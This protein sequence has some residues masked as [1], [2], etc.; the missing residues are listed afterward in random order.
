[1]SVRSVCTAEIRRYNCRQ[2]SLLFSGLHNSSQPQARHFAVHRSEVH[3]HLSQV[4]KHSIHDSCNCRYQTLL[5][6]DLHYSSQP[7]GRRFAL[8]SDAMHETLTQSGLYA[9]QKPTGVNAGV[10][11]CCVLVCTTVN[12]RVGALLSTGVKCM[13]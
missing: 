9:Q 12:L 2:K 13:P 6:S 8:H 3:A 5:C 10:K 11:L 7:Q 1:M 4:C